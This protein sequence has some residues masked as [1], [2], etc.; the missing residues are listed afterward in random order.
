[1]YICRRTMLPISKFLYYCRNRL[2]PVPERKDFLSANQLSKMI[3]KGWTKRQFTA[4]CCDERRELKHLHLLP[5]N[6][7]RLFLR[8]GR[9]LNHTGL[10]TDLLNFWQDKEWPRSPISGFF[11]GLVPIHIGMKKIPQHHSN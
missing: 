3:W 6:I 1:M 4:I 8:S 7:V 5:L 10:K 9:D 11:R 2:P